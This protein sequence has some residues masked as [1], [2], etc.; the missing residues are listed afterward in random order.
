MIAGML[1]LPIRANISLT[2][3]AGQKAILLY[4]RDNVLWLFFKKMQKPKN[5]KS[6]VT[7]RSYGTIKYVAA[8]KQGH[9]IFTLK[10]CHI[11][12]TVVASDQG[13]IVYTECLL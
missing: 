4:Q 12:A 13:C 9:Y 5:Y 10:H 7:T 8:R 2:G 11:V 1:V 6:S 3:R